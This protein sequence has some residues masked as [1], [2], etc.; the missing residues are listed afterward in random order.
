MDET[1]PF[2]CAITMELAE[3][4]VYAMD[5]RLYSLDAID[6]WLEQKGTSPITRERIPRTY[7]RPIELVEGYTAYCKASGISVP[8]IPVG[9]MTRGAVPST[10]S[11]LP[12]L[13]TLLERPHE[14]ERQIDRLHTDLTTPLEQLTPSIPEPPPPPPVYAS[15]PPTHLPK[16]ECFLRRVKRLRDALFVNL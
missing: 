15:P 13:E 11:R 3:L 14:T 2:M 4:P 9:M 7:L 12:D 1:P 5:G 8:P 10:P 6:R 16:Y